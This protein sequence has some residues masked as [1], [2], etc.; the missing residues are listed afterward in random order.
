M[1]MFSC[2]AMRMNVKRWLHEGVIP[3]KAALYE[4]ET[5]M[6]VAEKKLYVMKMRYLKNMCGVRCKNQME[7]RESEGELV[8]RESWAEQSVARRFGH[9]EIMEE[10]QLVRR[11]QFGR[12]ATNGMDRWCEKSVE[13]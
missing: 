7:K 3:Y 1:K 13:G 10:D 6:A 11:I 2:W 8:L 9:I 4:D 12:K 5:C